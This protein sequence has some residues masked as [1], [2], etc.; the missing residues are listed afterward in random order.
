MKVPIAVKMSYKPSLW[1][2][3]L[4]RSGIP[5]NSA[6]L[7]KRMPVLATSVRFGHIHCMKHYR[8]VHIA[9]KMSYKSG[10]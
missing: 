8:K 6:I 9:V 5:K 10:L 4:L 1:D 2:Q 3:G 7:P